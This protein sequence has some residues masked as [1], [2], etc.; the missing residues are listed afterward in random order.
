MP[1][2]DN[3]KTLN[4][5][6]NPELRIRKIHENLGIRSILDAGAGHGGVFDNGYWTSR[7]MD[8]RE[9]CDI[10]WMRPMPANWST[11][12][13]VDIC[14][15]SKHYGEK[16]FD[17]VQCTEVLEHIKESRKAIEEICRVARKFV[18]ITSAD[19]GHHRGPEQDAIEK[20][21]K[22]QAYVVQPSISDLK[23]LGFE[24]Y[25]EELEKRQIV[26]WRIFN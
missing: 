24:V 13:G 15:L 26:A 4:Y 1:I 14:E 22:H 21:N 2:Y 8:R 11:R 19:E 20:F 12:V 25:V 9:A 23:D 3:V 5:Y 6:P 10:Y 18:F 17:M 7:E 16:S